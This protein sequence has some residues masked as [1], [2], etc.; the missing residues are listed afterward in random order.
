MRGKWFLD[1]SIF[2]YSFDD[3]DPLKRRTART[4][5]E[6]SLSDRAGLISFQVVQEFC[7]VALR[8]FA[9]PFSVQECKVYL[10]DVL[11]PL[12]AVFPTLALYRT[13]LDTKAAT[14]LNFSD[15]LIVASAMQGGC[16]IIYSEDLPVGQRISGMT[17]RNPFEGTRDRSH[18]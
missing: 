6:Q 13:A 4:L 8:K 16:T 5:I 2:V 12:C 14:G 9:T 15:A 3:R 10:E 1:T 11:N 17:V 18:A 7:N